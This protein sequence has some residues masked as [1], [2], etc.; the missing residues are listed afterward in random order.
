MRGKRI[1]RKSKRKNGGIGE[2][3]EKEEEEEVKEK[4][5]EDIK[6]LIHEGNT[7]LHR[8]AIIV[9]GVK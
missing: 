1:K 7:L 6:P 3:E 5:E 8:S 9:R 4:R 2:E